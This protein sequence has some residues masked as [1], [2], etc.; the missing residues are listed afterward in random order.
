VAGRGG[1][2]VGGICWG[3]ARGLSPLPSPHT[4]LPTPDENGWSRADGPAP[5]F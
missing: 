2:G 3:R 1:G 4:P 5:T